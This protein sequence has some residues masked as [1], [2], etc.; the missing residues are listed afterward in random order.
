MKILM[1]VTGLILLG[2]MIDR[3]SNSTSVVSEAEVTTSDAVEELPE[4]EAVTE[5]PSAQGAVS[6]N[7]EKATLLSD[8]VE[9]EEM[10]NESVLSD[11]VDKEEKQ[12][13][14]N[15]AVSV[16]AK[17]LFPSISALLA[18]E[19]PQGGDEEKR[20]LLLEEF[21]QSVDPQIEEIEKNLAML[22]A[23]NFPHKDAYRKLGIDK[24]SALNELKE[25][26][27]EF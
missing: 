3:L 16:S 1:F 8:T 27:L 4:S 10:V 21:V 15:G 7:K 2:F 23:S 17:A 19:Q 6:L 5:M 12:E 18:E 13:E 24:I 14:E 20:R 25:K 11:A 26:A 9:K 22:E